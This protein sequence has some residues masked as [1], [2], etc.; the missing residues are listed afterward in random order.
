MTQRSPQYDFYATPTPGGAA[1]P[2]VATAPSS[3]A[4]AVNQFGTPLGVPG[5][6]FGGAPPAPVAVPS[7][8]LAARVASVPRW[9]WRIV[10]PLTVMVVLG[11]FGVGRMGFLDVVHRDPEL[12][13]VLAGQ[14]A[15]LTS[16]EN[17]AAAERLFEEDMTGTTWAHYVG[18]R[19]LTVVVSPVELT[20]AELAADV[21]DG[22]GA[23]TRT[24]SSWCASSPSSDWSWCGRSADGVT[25]EVHE[26]TT[27]LVT[28]A[29]VV[30]E[31]VASL[32]R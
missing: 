3:P 18:E 2:G 31:V 21:G 13:A 25:I 28:L 27:D 5:A 7:P 4:P 19:A 24:G 30:D 9:V 22:F 23:A 8:S 32:D 11:L 26:R 20:D 12:P 1:P 17:P 15:A 10:L 16:E 14:T 6:A 29:A